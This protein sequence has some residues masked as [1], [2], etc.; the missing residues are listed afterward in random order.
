MKTRG[1]KG[2]FRRS[3]REKPTNLSNRKPKTQIHLF[4]HNGIAARFSPRIVWKLWL[5]DDG[6][7]KSSPTI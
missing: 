6:E 2:F 7:Q 3:K 4:H 5:E 1:Q